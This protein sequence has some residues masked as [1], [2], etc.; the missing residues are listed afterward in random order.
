MIKASSEK[1]ITP[2]HM[3]TLG[4]SCALVCCNIDSAGLLHYTRRGRE[5]LVKASREEMIKDPRFYQG[6]GKGALDIS[7]SPE[8]FLAG[9]QPE[10]SF[11]F[12]AN[13][14]ALISVRG[15]RPKEDVK[16]K[17]LPSPGIPLPQ[18]YWSCRN[19]KQPKV[20]PQDPSL[21][22]PRFN[23]TCAGIS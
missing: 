21:Q 3:G 20:R 12:R 10:I 19:R 23:M 22:D 18:Y 14:R 9:Y 8:A 1:H 16:Q 13:A 5:L 4:A 15:A 7:A 11:P 2:R 17:V 6:L